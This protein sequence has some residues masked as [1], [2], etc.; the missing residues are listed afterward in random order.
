MKIF[1]T[2]S[3][4]ATYIVAIIP[5][6]TTPGMGSGLLVWVLLWALRDYPYQVSLV[7]ICQYPVPYWYQK[8][9]IVGGLVNPIRESSYSL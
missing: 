7:D 4:G 9:N 5:L 2:S 3:R 1:R 6:Y 8:E